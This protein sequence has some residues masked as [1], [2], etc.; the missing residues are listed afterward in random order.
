[1][2]GALSGGGRS[3]FLQL[4]P[5]PSRSAPGRCGGLLGVGRWAAFAKR[6]AVNGVG[7]YNDHRNRPQCD[8][9]EWSRGVLQ[10]PRVP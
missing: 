6:P 2:A 10:T 3:I 9:D 8:E 1:M 4:D 5:R 7:R